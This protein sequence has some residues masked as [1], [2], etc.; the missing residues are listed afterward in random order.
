MPARSFTFAAYSSRRVT[1]TGRRFAEAGDMTRVFRQPCKR[2]TEFPELTRNRS[3]D[4]PF[5]I[6]VRSEIQHAVVNKG[7]D[8]LPPR[9]RGCEPDDL[10]PIPS[11]C[12]LTPLHRG[13]STGP[14]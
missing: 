14:L 2:Y 10:Q 4:Q 11:G 5:L 6:R 7:A 9:V 13:K 8:G 12:E 3:T 1:S